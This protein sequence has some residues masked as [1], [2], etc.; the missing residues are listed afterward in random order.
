MS[1]IFTVNAGSSSVKFS[2]YTQSAEPELLLV[3]QVE[4]MGADAQLVLNST[5]KVCQSLGPVDH[6]GALIAILHAAAA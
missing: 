1:L 4:N 6:G 5:P 2:I 3:G